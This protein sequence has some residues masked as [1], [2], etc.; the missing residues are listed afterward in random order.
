MSF[1]FCKKKD[2]N[3]LIIEP[4]PAKY[5]LNFYTQMDFVKLP[6]GDFDTTLGLSVNL[7]KYFEKPENSVQAGISS[8]SCN[9]ISLSAFPLNPPNK[10]ALISPSNWQ[11]SSPEIG[12]VNYLD[13]SPIPTFTNSN[14]WSVDS[15]DNSQD[16]IIDFSSFKDYDNISVYLTYYF[17]SYME[18]QFINFPSN[19]VTIKAVPANYFPFSQK[20]TLNVW[21]TK[22]EIKTVGEKAVYINKVL[23]FQIPTKIYK[24]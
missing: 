22:Y 15:I 4:I 11:V 20:I 7:N 2:N 21:V 3:D 17:G 9:S 5:I 23:N 18:Q 1:S 14:W 16:F 10:L 12:T 8:A 19:Q 13:V 6:S 24:L